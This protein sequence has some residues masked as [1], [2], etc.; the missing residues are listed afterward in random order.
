MDVTWGPLSVAGASSNAN[1]THALQ[2][3]HAIQII[4]KITIRDVHLLY[5]L[6]SD[7]GEEHIQDTCLN[8]KTVRTGILK[9]IS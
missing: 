3:D 5:I 4:T 8:F 2:N 6:I 1:P 7:A 9:T